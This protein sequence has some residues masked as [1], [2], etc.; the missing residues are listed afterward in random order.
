MKARFL[1][2]IVLLGARPAVW[3]RALLVSVPVA[4]IRSEP[5]E[6]V[7]GPE[8][9][10]LQETQVL[11]GE[12]LEVSGEKDGWWRVRVPGQKEWSHARSWEGYPGWIRKEFTIEMPSDWPEPNAVVSSAKAW[13]V[14]PA[15]DGKVRRVLLSV[16]TP[17]VAEENGPSK[18]RA[19]CVDGSWGAIDPKDLRWLRAGPKTEGAGACAASQ[20]ELFL[21]TPYLWGGAERRFACGSGSHPYRRGLFGVGPSCL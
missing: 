1:L 11:Y 16:G 6:Y 21:G 14:R 8:Q 18:A 7:L 15:P 3:G 5:A 4:D 13:L 10:P 17:V 12:R 19:R 20:A 9:D 2:V